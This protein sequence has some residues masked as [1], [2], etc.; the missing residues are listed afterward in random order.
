MARLSTTEQEWNE[1]AQLSNYRCRDCKEII[2]FPDQESY[3]RN[4]LCAPCKSARDEER[5]NS[6]DPRMKLEEMRSN[7]LSLVPPAEEE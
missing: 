1:R 2:G 7:A 3:F 4:G 6:S 5:Q